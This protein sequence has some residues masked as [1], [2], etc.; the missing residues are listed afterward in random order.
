MLKKWH[1]LIVIFMCL[2]VFAVGAS[3]EDI[4]K[5]ITFLYEQATV[6]LPHL[7][8]WRLHYATTAGGPYLPVKDANGAPLVIPY[9]GT[10]APEYTSAQTLT[11]PVAPGTTITYYFVMTAVN[12]DNEESTFSAEAI[13]IDEN[14]V[15]DGTHGVEFTSPH[16]DVTTPVK[17]K[18]IIKVVNP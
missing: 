7:K 12:L 15:P 6:D 11:V 10:P 8:E 2:F 14:G 3:A 17:V 18:I 5:E 16:P 9:D 13:N 1:S 4:T